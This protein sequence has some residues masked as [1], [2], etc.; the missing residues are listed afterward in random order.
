MRLDS[1]RPNHPEKTSVARDAFEHQRSDP[2]HQRGLEEE[3]QTDVMASRRASKDVVAEPAQANKIRNHCSIAADSDV[4]AILR[5]LP[6]SYLLPAHRMVATDDPERTVS[7]RRTRFEE[8]AAD[9]NS[10]WRTRVT[11][12]GNERKKEAQGG[13]D[14]GRRSCR[15][16]THHKARVSNNAQFELGKIR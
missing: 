2:S 1:D 8:T 7:E 13:S 9:S 11:Q 15:L 3:R 16:K 5:S 14:D 6:R 12:C 4:A 10:T